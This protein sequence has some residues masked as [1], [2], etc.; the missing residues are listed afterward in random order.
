VATRPGGQRRGGGVSER[1]SGAVRRLALTGGPG[2]AVPAG[3]V[4]NR[5]KYIQRFKRIQNS[6]KLWLIQKVHSCALK[7]GNKI[8]L[9]RV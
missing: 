5:F 1:E 8:W 2:S 3:S 7:I 4:L 9:E 6:F